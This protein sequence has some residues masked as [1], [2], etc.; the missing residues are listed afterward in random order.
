[1]SQ[2]PN[3]TTIK[4]KITTNLYSACGSVPKSCSI[5]CDPMNCSM[6]GFLVLHYLPEFAQTHVHLVSDA[7]QSSHPL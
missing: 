4:G 7:I 1:M 2:Y 5:L 6:P 3:C